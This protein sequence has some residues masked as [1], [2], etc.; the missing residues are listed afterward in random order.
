M[1]PVREVQSFDHWTAKEVHS[2]VFLDKKKGKVYIQLQLAK[3]SKDV[4]NLYAVKRQQMSL[5]KKTHHFFSH[6]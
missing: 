4:S 5:N 2:K 3:G 1:S 6:E